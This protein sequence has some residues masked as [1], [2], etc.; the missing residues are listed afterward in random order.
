ML[1]YVCDSF[2]LV[3]YGLAYFE[4]GDLQY[5]FEGLWYPT[6]ILAM[7]KAIVCV[8]QLVI[9][10]LRILEFDRINSF[11]AQQRRQMDQALQFE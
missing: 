5:V 7:G 8:Y 4:T 11:M 10:C 3:M 9:S 1:G 2:Y 6:V